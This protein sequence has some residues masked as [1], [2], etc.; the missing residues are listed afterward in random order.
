MCYLTG[1]VLEDGLCG[2]AGRSVKKH[3]RCFILPEWFSNA[4]NLLGQ[5]PHANAVMAGAEAKIDQLTR[6]AFYVF[7][8]GTVIK[9]K[10]CVCL[11]KEVAC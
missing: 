8:S 10:E 1:I 6:A 5:Y 11:L 7:G 4:G 2:F 9:N 3:N